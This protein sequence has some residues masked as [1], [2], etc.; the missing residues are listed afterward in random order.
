M[1]IILNNFSPEGASV[2]FISEGKMMQILCAYM[3]IQS[4]SV[5]YNVII[6]TLS[7]YRI[8]QY[9]IGVFQ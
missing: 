7:N 1:F 3:H 8:I 4:V 5:P 6:R 9:I 2:K